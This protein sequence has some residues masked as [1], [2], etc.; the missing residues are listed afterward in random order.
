MIKTIHVATVFFS[1]LLFVS[2][3]FWVYIL[4]RQQLARWLKIVPHV[5]DTVLLVTGITL[6]IQ[7]QQYPLVHSWL[8]VKIICLLIYILLGM[9]AMKWQVSTKAG[10]F[11]WIAAILV[12]LYMISVALNKN[13]LP[14]VLS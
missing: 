3:G 10:L 7:V 5:N 2:R 4:N 6:A 13:P 14:I 8:T 11:S 9:V 12:F 1:I